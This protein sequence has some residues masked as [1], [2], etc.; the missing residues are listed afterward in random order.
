M[1]KADDA[2][3][4]VMKKLIADLQGIHARRGHFGPTEGSLA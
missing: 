1:T 3:S 2:L 4:D